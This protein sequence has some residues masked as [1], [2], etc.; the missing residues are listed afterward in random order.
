MTRS[1][2][3]T[4]HKQRQ[5]VSLLEV[6][7][8]VVL[9][10]SSAIALLHLMRGFSQAASRSELEVLA[11]SRCESVL[12][13]AIAAKNPLRFPQIAAAA[14]DDQWHVELQT[15]PTATPAVQQV[16]V[17]T[18]HRLTPNLGTFELTRLVYT[19]GE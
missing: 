8:A 13:L 9:F 16:T 14:N 4:V 5:G 12:S 18:H 6:L 10:S 2:S 15:Q 3:M 19:E 7:C 1:K 11:A 17:I